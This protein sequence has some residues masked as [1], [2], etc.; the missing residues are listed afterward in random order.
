MEKLKQLAKF[1]SE[2]GIP[3]PYIRDPKTGMGSISATMVVVSFN[4]VLLGIIGKYGAKLDINL[5]EALTLFE[6]SCGIYFGR[7]VVSTPNKTEVQQKEN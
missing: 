6:V 7:G 2:K 1:M 4:L 5:N 3:L